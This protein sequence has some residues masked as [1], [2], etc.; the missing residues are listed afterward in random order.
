MVVVKK[1]GNNSQALHFLKIA[2]K[3]PRIPNPYEKIGKASLWD[4]F[5]LNGELK[6]NYIHATKPGTIVKQNKRNLL[7]LEE[8]L[9]FHD[10]LVSL[11]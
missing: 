11:L 1:Y 10:V 2:H 7:V 4:W 9:E 3:K 5:T 8:H 6:P